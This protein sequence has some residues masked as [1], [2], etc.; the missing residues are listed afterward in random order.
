MNL[1]ENLISAKNRGYRQSWL[2]AYDYPSARLLDESGIDLIL[3]GDSLGMV[4]LGQKDTIDVTLDEIIHHLKAVR[5]GVTRAPVAADLPFGT[6]A[7]PDQA[8]ASSICLIDAG[9]DAVKLEGALPEQASLLTSR[10]IAVIGH[11]GMLPQQVREE[12]G[13]HRKGK[14]ETEAESLI[15]SAL[16]LQSAGCCAL[17]LELVEVALSK[18]I[19]MK[20][21]IPTIGIGSGNSCDGQILVTSDLIGLQPWF[22]PS[23][24]KPKADLA[25]PFRNAV[26][27]FISDVQTTPSP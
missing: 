7:T 1:K 16:D 24:V 13:Y 15:R 8:L 19:S 5:R 17:V 20:L 25:T 14:T 3:V 22:R 2:T 11:L 9:A 12:G 27:E 4:V 21:D 23:F 10:G 18:E 6:Y 26:K